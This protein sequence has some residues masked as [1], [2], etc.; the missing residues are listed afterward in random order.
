[1]DYHTEILHKHVTINLQFLIVMLT[2]LFTL[3]TTISNVN[4]KL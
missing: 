3:S 1:M 4:N 2:H